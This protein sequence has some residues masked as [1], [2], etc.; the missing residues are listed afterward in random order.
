MAAHLAH[1][2]PWEWLCDL[3]FER[4]APMTRR[5]LSP[6]EEKKIN[7]IGGVLAQTIEDFHRTAKE[8][9]E[10]RAELDPRSWGVDWGYTIPNI[11]GYVESVVW[12]YV[13]L[14]MLLTDPHRFAPLLRGEWNNFA[15]MF[16]MMLGY[17]YSDHPEELAIKLAPAFDGFH[18]KPLTAEV[19]QMLR[20]HAALLFRCMYLP[21]GGTEMFNADRISYEIKNHRKDC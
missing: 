20:D 3:Y 13:Q 12:G 4:R 15:Y 6:A 16:H 1:K 7:H 19:M 2:I 14:N 17:R 10:E 11:T 18:L 5:E 9:P 21:P 8:T